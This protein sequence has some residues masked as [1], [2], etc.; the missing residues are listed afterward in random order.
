MDSTKLHEDEICVAPIAHIA[1]QRVTLLGGYR[2]R[3]TFSNGAAGEIDISDLVEFRGVLARLADPAIFRQVRID[4]RGAL[5][6][7][8]DIDMDSN[9]LYYATMKLANPLALEVVQ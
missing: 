7:P 3:L 2:V 9:L 5:V 1:I 6:W 8:G 4:Q